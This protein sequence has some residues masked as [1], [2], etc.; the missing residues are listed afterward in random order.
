MITLEPQFLIG[1]C[2]LCWVL[3]KFSSVLQLD[4]DRS[5]RP[6]GKEQRKVSL[7]EETKE[8]QLEPQFLIGLC[9]LC[10]LLFKFSSI[11]L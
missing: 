9:F 11:L 7:A 2:F 5:G 10:Y 8:D 1:L 6:K 3:F 4:P